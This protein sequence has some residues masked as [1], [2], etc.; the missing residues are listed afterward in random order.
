MPA[1]L[2]EAGVIVNRDEEARLGQDA[3]RAR[4]AEAV[5]QSMPDCVRDAIKARGVQVPVSAGVQVPA[6]AGV[7][8]PIS[9]IDAPVQRTGAR[10]PRHKAPLAAS[11]PLK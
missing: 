1:V 10:T 2:F 8:A 6:S 11:A 9:S 3:T 4:I 5:A 7:P